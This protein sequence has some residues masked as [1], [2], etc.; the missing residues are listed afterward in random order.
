MCGELRH[1]QWTTRP[2]VRPGGDFPPEADLRVGGK[3]V[4]SQAVW[5]G[6]ARQESLAQWEKGGWKPGT[7]RIQS[8]TEKGHEFP[9]PEGHVVKVMVLQKQKAYVAVVTRPA[10]TEVEKSI[11]SRYP[12][13]VPEEDG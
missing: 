7:L 6:F 2:P 13:V 1:S 12:V 5:N 4:S 11:H 8:F 10:K 9:V 3:K